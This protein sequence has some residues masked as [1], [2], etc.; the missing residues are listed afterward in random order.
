M[1][2]ITG[3]EDICLFVFFVYALVLSVLSLMFTLAVMQHVLHESLIY[4]QMCVKRWSY[5]TL[6]G[7]MQRAQGSVFT[8]MHVFVW[9][10]VK[11]KFRLYCATRAW[12]C[13]NESR[14]WDNFFLSLVFHKAM[15][16]CRHYWVWN[17]IY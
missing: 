11:W 13:S 16:A 12:S 4:N 8:W 17:D 6:S 14:L 3:C 5:R 10:V 15:V 2:F 7:T 9:A 1:C